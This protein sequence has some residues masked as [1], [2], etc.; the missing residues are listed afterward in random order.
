MKYFPLVHVRAYIRYRFGRFEH[1][2]THVRGWP[3][4]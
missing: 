1:V 3:N 4:R 2:R